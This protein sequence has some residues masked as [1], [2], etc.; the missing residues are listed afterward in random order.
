MVCECT[1]LL[2]TTACEL[3]K[4][5]PSILSELFLCSNSVDIS[6]DVNSTAVQVLFY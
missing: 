1:W 2:S 4:L 5:P 3:I 6:D